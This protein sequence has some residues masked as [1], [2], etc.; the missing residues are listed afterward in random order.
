MESHVLLASQLLSTA[1]IPVFAGV[2][3]YVTWQHTGVTLLL[4]SPKAQDGAAHY[5]PVLESRQVVLQTCQRS[6]IDGSR[7]GVCVTASLPPDWSLDW[8]LSRHSYTAALARASH[9]TPCRSIT[10]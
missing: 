10:P 3:R 9:L 1:D 2:V 6:I 7:A 5:K 4:A 8:G